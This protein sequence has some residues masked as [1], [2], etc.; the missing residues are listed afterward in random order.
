MPTR[1]S[2]ANRWK[3]RRSQAFRQ[4]A[5][6]CQPDA[7][8]VSS[9]IDVSYLTGFSGEDSALLFGRDWAVL[10]TDF[11]FQEQAAG[12]CPGVEILLRERSQSL[13]A[14]AGLAARGHSVRSL[15]FQEH[16]L[17]VAQYRAL[18]AAV[19]GIKTEPVSG[20][21]LRGRAQ[22]DTEEIR[23]TRRAVQ[24]AEKAFRQLIAPGSAG[25]VGRSERELQAELEHHMQ[26]AGADR[27]AFD[28]IVAAG[29]NGSMCHYRPGNRK[30]RSGEALLIDWGAEVDGY[31]SDITR[32]VFLGHVDDRLREVYQVVLQAHD[33]AVAEIRPGVRC[34]SID[35]IARAIIDQAG[36]GESF[37][38]GL[39]HGIGREIHEQPRLAGHGAERL[40]QG[41]IVTVEPGIYLPGLGGVRIEDDILVTAD[42]H[43]R[44][45]RLPRTLK[46]MTLR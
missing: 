29:P 18:Q 43:Q 34:S 7:M 37:G 46:R 10:I 25:L 8:Y 36:Y 23:L 27:P 12:E 44:L 28:T 13:E 20:I 14:A 22:K 40:R 16:H 41:M 31:R 15:A 1:N 9:T 17:T 3:T 33:A 2:A 42:G 19:D 38:H 4:A 30:L 24:I 11:R 6:K 5:R 26:A 45:N 35:K 21:V 39:G 32:V